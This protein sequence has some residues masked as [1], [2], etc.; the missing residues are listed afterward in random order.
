MKEFKKI[1]SYLSKKNIFLNVNNILNICLPKTIFDNY[2]NKDINY[3]IYDKNIN[4]TQIYLSTQ[5]GVI[6]YDLKELYN[7]KISNIIF[8]III[9]NSL[10]LNNILSDI[11]SLFNILKNDGY[12]LIFN[13]NKKIIKSFIDIYQ[14]VIKIKYFNNLI[15]I[16]KIEKSDL[17]IPIYIYSII[18]YI[19]N[20]KPLNTKINLLNLHK[21]DNKTI[22]W[23]FVLNSNYYKGEYQ[24][25]YNYEIEKYNTYINDIEK[26]INK[27]DIVSLG[28]IK[29]SNLYNYLKKDINT[30][31]NIGFKFED[32]GFKKLSNLFNESIY[33][34][35]KI[36]N[37]FSSFILTSLNEPAILTKY[38]I[39]KGIKKNKITNLIHCKKK[40]NNNCIENINLF[41]F[42]LIKNYT[43]KFNKKYEFIFINIGR[44]LIY[45][46]LIKSYT[47]YKG[48]LL[49]NLLYLILSIQKEKGELYIIMSPINDTLQIQFIQLLHQFYKKITFKI[50]EKHSFDYYNIVIHATDFKGILPENLEIFKN[51]YSLFFNTNI[52]QHIENILKGKKVE[53]LHLESIYTNPISKLLIKK[54]YHFNIKFYSKF[55]KDVKYGLDIYYFLHQKTT[56]KEQ[57]KFIENELFK[58]QYEQ[59]IKKYKNS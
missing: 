49:L 9:I 14:N 42:N 26:K 47:Y 30:Q 20:F 11:I 28:F 46:N 44:Y 34:N 57:K 18:E 51:T 36:K 53:N 45:N 24:Y 58:V 31:K 22:N 2:I 39:L 35:N 56:T 38:L 15:I 43:D 7:S 54:I 32:R 16:Q 19:K 25:G 29:N 4:K 50:F 27:K 59:F 12:L 33:I 13:Y 55:I 40:N 17:N 41:N 48:I 5:T 37:N 10:C 8:D 23:N 6:K 52:I 1:F 21:K 3:Y